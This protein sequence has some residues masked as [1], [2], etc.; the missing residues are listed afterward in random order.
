MTTTQVPLL[1]AQDCVNEAT[2]ILINATGAVLRL[3]GHA[4]Q[5]RNDNPI[6][7]HVRNDG[8]IELLG[9]ANR[10]S[11]SAALGRN[12]AW[13]IGG[14][15]R[16]AATSATRVQDVQ[17]CW[18]SNLALEGEAIKHIADGVHVGGETSET[19]KFT[20]SGGL[21]RYIGTFCY[22]NTARQIL[23]GGEEYQHIEIARGLEPKRIEGIVRTRG[24]FRQDTSNVGGLQIYGA[25]DIG[26]DGVFPYISDGKGTVELGTTANLA[27]R[28]AIAS[29]TLVVRGILAIGIKELRAFAGMVATAS[30]KA[31]IV[32]GTDATLRFYH[33]HPSTHG[34]LRLDFAG[35]TLIVLG[36]LQNDLL[37]STNT[38][39]HPLC[40]TYYRSSLPQVLMPTATTHPYGNLY[41][42]HSHKTLRSGKIVLAGALYMHNA[43]ADMGQSGELHMTSA[44][45]E[46][47]YDKSSEVYGAMTR[48]ISSTVAEYTFNN[49][50]THIRYTTS[51]RP[52]TV[53][54]TVFPKQEPPEF[55]PV[56]D[57]RRL[58]RWQWND[59]V[60]E[61]LWRCTLRLAYTETEIA[62]PFDT[63]NEQIVGIY[64]VSTQ[65]QHNTAP[66]RIA[67]LRV[68]RT[69]ARVHGVGYVEYSELTNAL[70]T[71][72]SVYSGDYIVL[73]GVR[74]KVRSVRSG[75][76]SNPLTW[77]VMREPDADDSVEINHTVH[78]GFRR[79]ALDG[80]SPE[81][82]MR[83]RGVAYEYNADTSA[84]V[85]AKAV[86][87]RQRASDS[88]RVQSAA[89]LIGSRESSDSTFADEAPPRGP[90]C[91]GTVQIEQVHSTSHVV[92]EMLHRLHSMNAQITSH[93]ALHHMRITAEEAQG[94][95]VIYAPSSA[96]SVSHVRIL[97]LDNR[98]H[99]ANAGCLEVQERFVSSG[100]VANS[101]IVRTFASE[102][103]LHQD[104]LGSVTE[105][106]L[107][108][109]RSRQYVPALRYS[110]LV[111]LGAAHKYVQPRVTGTS[112]CQITV[113]DS[114][115]VHRDVL[116]TSMSE[117]TIHVRGGMWHE[118]RIG[119]S[120]HDVAVV[121]DGVQRQYLHG[122]GTCMRLLMQNPQGAIQREGAY[123][124]H[125]ALDLLQGSLVC[126]SP[127][128]LRLASGCSITRFPL[129]SLHAHTLA[130]GAITIR[131]RGEGVMLA[132]DELLPEVSVLDIGNR[133]GYQCTRSVAV[134]DSLRVTSRLY[135]DSSGKIFLSFLPQYA[136]PLFAEDSA[137]IVG[138]V[139][140][141]VRADSIPR[142]F[143]NRYTF[144]QVL[145]N[146][147]LPSR[148]SAT[149]CVRPRT[150]PA[151]NDDT[152]K[153]RRGI[154]LVLYDTTEYRPVSAIVR[155]GYAWRRDSTSDETYNVDGARAVLQ[156]WNNLYGRW[157]THGTPQRR[158]TRSSW[159]STSE[160]GY[161]IFGVMDSVQLT[162]MS[163]RFFALGVDSTRTLAPS[164]FFS[165]NAWLEGAL[166][167]G[168]YQ[169]D[170]RM[171]TTLC[172]NG[173]LPHSIVDTQL[174]IS[175]NS[176][177]TGLG[178]YSAVLA[179]SATVEAFPRTTVDW[180]LMEV[181]P[182]EIRTA[183]GL[184]WRLTRVEQDS[185]RLFLP[186]LL[187]SNGALCNTAR[188]Y[189]IPVELPEEWEHGGRCVVR[190]YHRNHLPVEWR[191]TLDIVP[192]Q[193]IIVDW[194]DTARVAGGGGALKPVW[195][196][197]R[198]IFVL[199]AGDVCEESSE[200]P[201]VSRAD[202][203]ACVQSAWQ[204][205]GRVG[206]WRADVDCDGVVTTR[207]ANI[208]WNNRG[209]KGLRR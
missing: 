141:I 174:T 54:L 99:I 61:R 183:D 172:E 177:G 151:P 52:Q 36:S 109:E 193:R 120:T 40:T 9:A 194:S 130:E 115:E 114:L 95:I 149:M 73:R 15:V 102:N 18:Y 129:S 35:N 143:N 86:V 146:S 43:I 119:S 162:P 111:L 209:I 69:S 82:Q 34:T 154:E 148:M 201:M 165:I 96:R 181:L 180:M 105:F 87:I 45:A 188:Q 145:A 31:S 90:W 190:L 57:V 70:N 39:F 168:I 107:H 1:I 147:T 106:A 191:D 103:M 170:V 184:L 131:T 179:Q 60:V 29:G 46:A 94:N 5:I 14:L 72:Y 133:G 38:Y 171:R 202:Y 78:V 199:I 150:A 19:G 3:R 65:K 25:I 75:R 161:W 156:R 118:G 32:V 163:S 49:S 110:H 24:L 12:L 186:L 176:I 42:E 4:A 142:V 127:L 10:F 139:R 135:L 67:A 198:V 6:V 13:R 169:N 187:Q 137:E 113:H 173:L 200:N 30:E 77:N 58:I 192:Q 112:L 164:I 27:A 98:G 16:Y 182:I 158:T 140:R 138:T 205:F 53:T 68:A 11:G 132:S 56:H 80:M 108:N 37:S 51:N 28:N 97:A 124:I 128:P 64:A 85:L 204:M 126:T 20:A 41:L 93:R 123:Y 166:E 122:S 81:G 44:H 8:T 208:I 74:E 121:L 84:L 203:D 50:Q 134:R 89:L 117:C 207:D 160:Q 26:T 83:E 196:A 189:S 21:R 178:G 76:W 48:T 153:V 206:Y 47:L 175:A 92:S 100:I 91:F 152:S 63:R 197:D 23:L 71:P 66:R 33:T 88:S 55:S 116:L 101:G 2:G 62:S 136:Q 125:H 159:N 79:N 157:E 22:D 144:L 104:S 185:L 59:S 155:I 17:A 195:V 7:E 167:R